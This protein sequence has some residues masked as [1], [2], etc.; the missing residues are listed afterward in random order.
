MSV[1]K[2]IS[3]AKYAA[4]I[5]VHPDTVQAWCRNMTLPESRRNP[6]LPVISARKRGRFWAVDVDATERAQAALSKN[7]IERD[8]ARLRN[9]A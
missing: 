2:R 4:L 8:T 1:V 3:A 7:P 6:E 9:I 5:G